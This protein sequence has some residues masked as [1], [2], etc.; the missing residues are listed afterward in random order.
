MPALGDL[1]ADQLETLR[2]GVRL[3]ALRALRD[4]DAAEEVVQE[5]L[6]RAVAALRER[7]PE[8]GNLGAYVA[9]IARHV[10]A[11]VHRAQKRTV[12]LDASVAGRAD[13]GPDP[14]HTLISAAERTAVRAALAKLSLT[15]REIL[16]LS[17]FEGLTPAEVAAR[18]HQ[19]DAR[20]RKRKS[21]ALERLRRA[22]LEAARRPE[23]APAPTDSRA[24]VSRTPMAKEG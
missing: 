17:F 20:V 1:A 3:M 12:P 9:G 10:I 21:R 14:L 8:V 11:D 24:R 2:S 23:S 13:A 18:L 5:T 6:A 16:R 22:F 19:P 15:D 7:S 4:P